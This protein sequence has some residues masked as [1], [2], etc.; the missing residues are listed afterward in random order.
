M[1]VAAQ[2]AALAELPVSALEEL[3]AKR[4]LLGLFT[5]VER[6]AMAY[7]QRLTLEQPIRAGELRG[8]KRESL[9][10][11]LRSLFIAGGKSG[12]SFKAIFDDRNP[13]VLAW[14]R[15]T[16]AQL[17][18][19]VTR[20]T[21]QAIRNVISRAYVAG[22]APRAFAREVRR[23]VGLTMAQEGAVDRLVEKLTGQGVA[24]REIDRRAKAYADR[25]HRY[26]AL[27]IGR[28]ETIKSSNAGLQEGWMQASEQ[29][30]LPEG[31]RRKWIITPDD[32]LCELCEQMTGERA[33]AAL[34]GQFDTPNGP[35]DGPPM[36]PQCR[37][38]QGIARAE[39]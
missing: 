1:I 16:A 11:I 38:A 18:V 35:M 19:E 26:R 14:I 23:I 12:P 15:T 7:E 17:V 33:F 2:R 10:D 9:P 20:E 32:R 36:H 37:C 6:A 4:D 22:K 24:Q 29:G 27:N 31:A 5:L 30:L 3:A 8:A 28:T 13:R 34:D 25:L 39:A 21:K